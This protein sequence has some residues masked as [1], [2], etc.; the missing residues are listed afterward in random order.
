MSSFSSFSSLN[1]LHPKI[2]ER[3]IEFAIN[4]NPR[5]IPIE[6]D[7]GTADQFFVRRP[8]VVGSRQDA[9]GYDTISIEDA[10]KALVFKDAPVRFTSSAPVP[11]LLHVSYNI[12]NM[13]L[14][15]YRFGFRGASFVRKTRS[16]V[17][18]SRY[19]HPF[20]GIQISIQST[21]PSSIS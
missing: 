11:A 16:P 19:T 21:S 14:E 9:L 6:A 7:F 15:H 8:P 13:A 3:I 2:Q 10:K 4:A 1:L 17:H 5:T 18:F 12:R 20:F